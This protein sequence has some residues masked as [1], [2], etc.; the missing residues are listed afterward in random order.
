MIESK[1]FHLFTTLVWMSGLFGIVLTLAFVL[2]V[3]QRYGAYTVAWNMPRTQTSLFASLA[4]FSLGLALQIYALQGEITLWIAMVWAGLALLFTVRT[5]VATVA[6]FRQGWEYGRDLSL[7]N[8]GLP[9]PDNGGGWFSFGSV[10]AVILLLTNIGLIVLWAWGCEWR[11]GNMPSNVSLF[12][13]R[14][15]VTS[16]VEETPAPPVNTAPVVPEP[17]QEAVTPSE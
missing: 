5:I 16:D 11:W 15:C 17:T 9:I 3:R 8:A 10:I 2:H 14:L 13:Q 6:G 4:T 1:F 7:Y 12:V